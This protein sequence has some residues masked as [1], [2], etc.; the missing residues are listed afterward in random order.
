MSN[1]YDVT[2]DEWEE[3]RQTLRAM[4][5]LVASVGWQKLSSTL[6][7][8]QKARQLTNP[9][10][11]L[12]DMMTKQGLLGENV[13]LAI[14]L[15]LPQMLMEVSQETID[16]YVTEQEMRDATTDE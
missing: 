1:P 8:Q 15:G 5:E 11:S 4:Q 7:L 6:R 12:D 13:G 16:R 10:T 14:A 3:A 9:M 2:E